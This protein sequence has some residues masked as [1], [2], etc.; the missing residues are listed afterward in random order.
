MNEKI[1]TPQVQ[2]YINE[3]LNADVNRIALSKP[4]FEKIS[5]AELAGQIAAKKK[6]AHKLPTWFNLPFIYYPSLLSI[7]QCSSEHTATYKAN[8]VVGK[9]LIDLTSGFG[10]DS[11]FFSK[12]ME[13]VLSCEI[14]PELSEIS[15][16]NT[17]ILGANNLQCKAI[18]G[19]EFLKHTNLTFG[20]IYIDP[21]RRNEHQKVF[22]LK[23]CTPD[24]T[25]H[26]DLLLVKA[27]RILIKAA[28]LLDISA[29][30]SELKNVSEIHIISVKN[31][32]KELLWVIDKGY[33]DT[34]QIICAT[35]NETIKTMIIPFDQTQTKPTLV[36]EV[37]SGYLY[38][39]DVA[40]LKSGAFNWIGESFGLEK[41]HR[42]SQL[43]C[44]KTVNPAFL[45]RIFKINAVLNLN[46]LKKEKN[47]IG[48]V[49]VRNFPERAENLVKKYKIKASHDE[50]IVFTQTLAGYIAI[51]ATIIQH[52]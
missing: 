2:A 27:N 5:S 29:G 39:P 21:A 7:E 50:F 40:L 6:S 45:G 19:I 1:L 52:Y 12:R 38:E 20:T 49:I 44:S 47:L 46:E 24:V 35:L 8:L 43:Y 18:D 4:I 28:P 51:K 15:A 48:N 30:L 3:H 11:Y 13:N 42:Q 41:L 10:V 16:H 14:N 17:E 9:T 25:A 22:R 36:S 32:C 33:I 37:P 23:D 34:P 31:E 26:L